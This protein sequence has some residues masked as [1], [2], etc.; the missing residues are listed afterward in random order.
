MKLMYRFP[1]REPTSYVSG[2]VQSGRAEFWRGPHGKSWPGFSVWRRGDAGPR[3]RGGDGSSLCCRSIAASSTVE[4]LEGEERGGG[5]H[6]DHHKLSGHLRSPA[7][8]T[9]SPL[10]GE[11]ADQYMIHQFS[12]QA[13]RHC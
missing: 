9:H 6:R 1:R 12:P 5:A 3:R 13:Q 11:T 8:E 10:S 2:P 4:R 7:A